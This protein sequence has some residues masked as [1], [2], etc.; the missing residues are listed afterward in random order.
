M[1]RNDSSEMVLGYISVTKPSVQ[2]IFIDFDQLSYPSGYIRSLYRE[3]PVSVKNRSYW[4]YYFERG[5][6]VLAPI[7]DDNS[8]RIIGWEWVHKQCVRCTSMGGTRQKPSWWPN[9]HK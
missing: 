9:D 1:N 8:N 7:L 5:Y 4:S 3:I 2:R 6:Q